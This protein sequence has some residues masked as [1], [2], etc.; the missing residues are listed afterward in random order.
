[1]E[2]RNYIINRLKAKTVSIDE[3]NYDS[4]QAPPISAMFTPMD[5]LNILLSRK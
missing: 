2:N 4:L 1:M 5:L 3:F